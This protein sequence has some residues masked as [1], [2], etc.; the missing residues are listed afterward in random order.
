VSN[1]CENCDDRAELLHLEKVVEKIRDM[2]QAAEV[3]DNRREHPRGWRDALRK[4]MEV[5]EEK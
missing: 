5:V 4:V 1:L 2:A 3:Q